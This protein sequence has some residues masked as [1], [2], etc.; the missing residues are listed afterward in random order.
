M[1]PLHWASLSNAH[2]EVVETLL[3]AEEDA[4][5]GD[6]GGRTSDVVG[7]LPALM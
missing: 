5:K 1:T 6:I 3:A 4:N 2:L 7:S